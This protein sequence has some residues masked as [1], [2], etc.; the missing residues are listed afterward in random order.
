M[1]YIPVALNTTPKK[2]AI[3]VQGGLNG[4]VSTYT[5]EVESIPRDG[6]TMYFGHGG[7][8]DCEMVW[9]ESV[10]PGPDLATVLL[11]SPCS[12]AHEPNDVLFEFSQSLG[13]FTVVQDNISICK[14]YTEEQFLQVAC[15]EFMH[16]EN[17][18]YLKDIDTSYIYEIRN[19]M[20]ARHN[21]YATILNY[22]TNDSHIYQ[23]DD[24]HNGI[25]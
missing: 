19:L 7:L 25:Y 11:S 5:L 3:T 10:S 20:S 15:H 2:V 13:G 9:V 14:N 17:N 4:T 22:R 8:A 21:W 16:Q 23:W 12:T 1:P 18:G 24:A 6:A